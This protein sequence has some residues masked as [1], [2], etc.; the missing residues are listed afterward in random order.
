MTV[1]AGAVFLVA[2]VGSDGE[3]PVDAVALRVGVVGCEGDSSSDSTESSAAL[4]IKN[5]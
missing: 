5:K 2:G 1:S 4:T 3:P